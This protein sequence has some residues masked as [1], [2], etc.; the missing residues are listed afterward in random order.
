MK[1]AFLA[2][3]ALVLLAAQPAAASPL[4]EASVQEVDFGRVAVGECLVFN[5]VPEPDCVTRELTVTNTGDSLFLASSDAAASCEKLFR[6]RTCITRTAGWGGF[7]GDPASSCLSYSRWTLQPDN[8]W[9]WTLAPGE[10]CT[11][12]LVAQPSRKGAIHGYFVMWF[13]SEILITVQAAVIGQ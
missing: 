9:Y 3:A 2:A 5:N 12:V 6:E 10:S 4:L 7:L 13:G 1:R 8:H 11:M